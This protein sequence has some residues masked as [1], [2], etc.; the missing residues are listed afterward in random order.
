MFGPNVIK[1][2]EENVKLIRD[3]LKVAQSRQKSYADLK[4][5]EVV[6]EIGGRACL[7]VFP[8]RGVKLLE[9]RES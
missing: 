9:L 3:R 5:K 6:Y 2:S 7:R 4:R 1:E 8:L